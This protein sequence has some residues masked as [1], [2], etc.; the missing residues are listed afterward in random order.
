[1]TDDN[2][3]IEERSRYRSSFGATVLFSGVQLFQ[4]LI[5]IVRSKFVALFIGPAGMGIHSLL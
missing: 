3:I 5:K 1:M 2:K 4:I